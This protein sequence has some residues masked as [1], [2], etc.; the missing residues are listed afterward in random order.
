VLYCDMLKVVADTM[1]QADHVIE[2][3]HRVAH[4]DLKR[5]LLAQ[6]NMQDIKAMGVED[7]ST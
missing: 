2:H 6:T 5:S 1:G 4:A 7:A 3:L